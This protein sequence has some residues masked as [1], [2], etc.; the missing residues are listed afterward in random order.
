M[1]LQLGF[2][3]QKP[4]KE[5]TLVKP[6]PKTSFNNFPTSPPFHPPKI[7]TTFKALKKNS[8]Q[9]TPLALSSASSS[10]TPPPAPSAPRRCSCDRGR[11]AAR[12]RRSCGGRRRHGRRRGDR[13][14]KIGPRVI[15]KPL[16]YP[17]LQGKSGFSWVFSCRSPAKDLTFWV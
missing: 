4:K 15:G 11:G 1:E 10:S 7:P 9:P 14:L 5:V 13:L 17:K 16:I 6:K 12:P 8:A 2:A 3:F